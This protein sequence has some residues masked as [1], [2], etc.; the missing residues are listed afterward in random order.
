MDCILCL[1]KCEDNYL[2][3][4]NKLSECK[5]KYIVHKKCLEYYNNHTNIIKYNCYLCRGSLVIYNKNIY[6][7]YFDY[8]IVNFIAYFFTFFWTISLFGLFIAPIISLFVM[9]ASCFT[10]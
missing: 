4:P 7:N 2:Q 5:C 9:I 10:L 8:C 6:Y 1:D 3:F